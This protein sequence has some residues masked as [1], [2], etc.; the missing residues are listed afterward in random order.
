MFGLIFWPTEHDMTRYLSM[1]FLDLIKSAWPM[2]GLGCSAWHCPLA[3]F[4]FQLGVIL[5]L[6][7]F[8]ENRFLENYNQN[9]YLGHVKSRISVSILTK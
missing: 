3:M 5:W 8:L 1:L 2:T 7:V 9:M 6:F 4:T